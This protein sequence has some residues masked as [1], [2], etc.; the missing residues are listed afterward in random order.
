[1]FKD[2]LFS[3][4]LWGNCVAHSLVKH[5]KEYNTTH[6]LGLVGQSCTFPSKQFGKGQ[7]V[8][9][10]YIYIYIQVHTKIGCNNDIR[11]ESIHL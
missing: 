3:H 4:A 8:I 9:Y 2:V 1:M 11:L 5:S 7:Y 10:I 6:N